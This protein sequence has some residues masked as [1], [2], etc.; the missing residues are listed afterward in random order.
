MTGIFV[1]KGMAVTIPHY[2]LR[3]NEAGEIESESL[4][5]H[6]RFDV[7]PTWIQIG[8][9]HLEAALLAKSH[10]QGVWLGTDEVAKARAL[11]AEFEASM[12][13][14]V[15]VAIA[16]DAIYAVL[17]QHIVIPQSFA[18]R[19]RRGQTARYIQVAEIVRRAFALKKNNADQVRNHLREIYRLRDLAVHPSGKIQAP[20]LH[21]DLNVGTEWRFV[22]F[23]ATNAEIA[24][25][26]SAAML[27]E[28]ANGGKSRYP[29]V[30][31]YQQSL[32]MRLNDVFPQGPPSVP[33]APPNSAK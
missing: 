13:A 29:R 33:T 6:I 28:L 18:E 22:W 15:A 21:P 2:S 16:W 24:V 12:Q 7:G 1:S 17:R 26:V 30:T 10:L 25:S 23:R 3:L 31:E 20:I 8:Q 11:E 14:I 27:W 32:A 9:R 5:L 4:A 19:W